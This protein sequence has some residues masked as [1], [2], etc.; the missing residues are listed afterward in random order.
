MHAS[1]LSIEEVKQWS[2]AEALLAGMPSVDSSIVGY[3][4]ITTDDERRLRVDL[5][6]NAGY[7]CFQEVRCVEGSVYI[8]Y[9]ECIIVVNPGSKHVETHFLDGYFGHLYTHEELEILPTTFAALAASASE[10]LSFSAEGRLC[11]RTA[12]LGIDGVV[13]HSVQNGIVKGSGEWDPPGGWESFRLSVGT[14]EKNAA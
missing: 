3:V 9:G 2:G 11:W 8:G 5:Q 13:V 1:F 12:N 6:A 4:G 10:L 14:G 7:S